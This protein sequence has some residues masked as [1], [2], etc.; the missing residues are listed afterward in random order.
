MQE[1]SNAQVLPLELREFNNRIST[2][3]LHWLQ[4]VRVKYEP[5]FKPECPSSRL[6]SFIPGAPPLFFDLY[7]YGIKTS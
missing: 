2:V 4:S 6:D 7:R 1:V 3:L 5:L